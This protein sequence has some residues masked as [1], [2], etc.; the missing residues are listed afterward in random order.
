MGSIPISNKYHEGKMKSTLKRKLNVP[1]LAENK[2]D[3]TIFAW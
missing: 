2:A 1:E 3:G